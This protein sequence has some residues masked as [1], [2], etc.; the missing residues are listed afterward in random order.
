M[1]TWTDAVVKTLTGL[2]AQNVW[3]A[4]VLSLAA[5]IVTSFTP[6]SLSA[7]PMV[8]AYIEGS[9][10][11]GR[12]RA[13]HLSLVM[14]LGMA[15]T[16]GLFG[17]LASAIGHF[18]HEAG[19]W[20]SAL[21]GVLML[22]MALQM[23]GVIRLFPKEPDHQ[24]Q[25]HGHIHEEVCES[26]HTKKM[27]GRS[28]AGAFLTGALGGVFASHCAAPVMVALLALVAQS[29]HGPFWGIFLMALYAL[30]HSILLV[31]AGISYSI[32]DRWLKKPGCRMAGKWLRGTIGT[33]LLVLGIAL[34]L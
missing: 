25:G 14:A 11:V 31:L 23:W 33:V 28:Y 10:A 3:F 30:G 4:P 32:V 29:K 6:C 22:L 1:E 21:M 16:F 7:V 5:G 24:S 9:A 19:H 34:L 18:M 12:K 26:C 17:C 8:L 20:W 15:A 27:S 2:M 13:L